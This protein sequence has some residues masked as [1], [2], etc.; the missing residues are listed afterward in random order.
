MGVLPKDERDPVH[1]RLLNAVREVAAYGKKRGVTLSLETGQETADELIRFLDKLSE[2]KIGVN[3]DAANLVLYGMDDPSASLARVY[4]R[5][6][7]VHVKD[8]FP[9]AVAGQIGAEARLGEGK[10]EATRCLR[11]LKEKKFRGP[12]IIENYVWAV[13]HTD[14]LEELRMAKEFIER[15]WLA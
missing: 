6:T 15:I 3:F 14:P 12:L 11:L 8:G 7:S 2:F 13:S 4:D 10:A 9:P 1:Q 5:V